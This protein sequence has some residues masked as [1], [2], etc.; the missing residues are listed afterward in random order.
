V[1]RYQVEVI[2]TFD[3]DDAEALRLAAWEV[4][5]DRREIER[6]GKDIYAER[7]TATPEAALS[8]LIGRSHGLRDALRSLAGSIN[9][10]TYMGQYATPASVYPV[11]DNE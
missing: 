8:V 4:E 3:V 1:Q 11:M 2:L 5:A 10:M 9:G 7:A 6:E